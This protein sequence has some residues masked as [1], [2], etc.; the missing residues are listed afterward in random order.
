[1]LMWKDPHIIGE[2]R[3]QFKIMLKIKI[4]KEKTQTITT[5]LSSNGQYVETNNLLILTENQVLYSYCLENTQNKTNQSTHF[6]IW[7]Q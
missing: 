3:I 2:N 7:I 5:L 4:L 6:D 1:M